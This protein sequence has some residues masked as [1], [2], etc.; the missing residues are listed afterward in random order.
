MS[1][2]LVFI[3][4]SVLILIVLSLLLYLL[5]TTEPDPTR[6]AGGN[7]LRYVILGRRRKKPNGMLR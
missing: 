1:P 3:L 6:T 4:W 5:A 2:E 7:T